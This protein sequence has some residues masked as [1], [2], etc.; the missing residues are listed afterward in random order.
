MATYTKIGRIRPDY[1]DGWDPARSYTALEMVKSADNHMAY[2][3]KQD[4]PAGTPLTDETY[5]GV[6]L[7]VSD[8]IAESV[9]A[10]ER[11]NA[12]AEQADAAREAIKGD[13]EELSERTDQLSEEIGDTDASANYK[14][15]LNGY[16]NGDGRFV[17]SAGWMS[18]DFIPFSAPT[19]H[20]TF[21]AVGMEF[22]TYHNVWAYDINRETLGSVCR[23]T[24]SQHVDADF[25]LPEGTAYIRFMISEHSYNLYPDFAFEY[26]AG[27][28]LVYSM[29][30]LAE[31]H[32]TAQQNKSKVDNVLTMLDAFT[33]IA[34]PAD[35]ITGGVWSEIDSVYEAENWCRQEIRVEPNKQYT[36]DK[37][38]EAFSWFINDNLDNLGHI[39]GTRFTTPPGC[40]MVRLGKSGNEPFVLLDTDYSGT[41]NADLFPYGEYK[42]KDKIFTLPQNMT[43]VSLFE[44]VGVCGDSFSSG[45]IYG[46]EGAVE[47]KHYGISWPE[48]MGRKNGIECIPYAVPGRNSETWQTHES[49]LPALLSDEPCNLYIVMLG[50]NDEPALGTIADINEDY[51]QNPNTFYGNMGKIYETIK[52]HAP[53]AKFIFVTPPLGRDRWAAIR[54]IAEYYNV[55]WFATTDDP[56][57]MSD[58][59]NGNQSMGHPIA[60]TYAGMALAMERQIAA[61][62]CDNIGYFLDYTGND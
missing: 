17:E 8:V 46:V 36:V 49:C 55:P 4:V 7:D 32:V 33:N 12:A 50:I 61:C 43:T 20:A 53:S 23:Y 38:T 3:A 58:L 5:W 28:T 47:G 41:V 45:G 11:A 24:T 6:V 57:Y 27:D 14:N 60:V 52:T 25:V 59:Y 39:T 19:M 48:I 40:T 10:T 54:E 18:S 13:F 22:A 42:T 21:Y 15:L 51:A 9:A 2:I 1:A 29:P 35:F 16:I 56:F 30:R 44:R 37:I 34:A 31:S 62:M 26:K